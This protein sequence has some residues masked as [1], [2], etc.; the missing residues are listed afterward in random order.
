MNISADVLIVVDFTKKSDFFMV[1]VCSLKQKIMEARSECSKRNAHVVREAI[2]SLAPEQQEMI[3]MC[4]M[5][6]K[7][8]KLQG[9]R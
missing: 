2:A 6:A 3:E 7:A 9:R 1:Q 4:L 8:T 5:S